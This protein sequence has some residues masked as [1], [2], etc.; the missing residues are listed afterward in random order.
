[1]ALQVALIAIGVFLGLAGEEW[2]E[3]RENRQLAAETLHRF[4]AEVATNRDT[5]SASWTITSK[6]SRS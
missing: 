1:M 3:D 5:V 6:S 4:R 2:R